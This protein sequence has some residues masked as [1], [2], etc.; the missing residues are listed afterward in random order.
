MANTVIGNVGDRATLNYAGQNTLIKCNII[1]MNT[2]ASVDVSDM[3]YQ[4]ELYEDIMSPFM[5]GKIVLVDTYNLPGL[6]PILGEE[7]FELEYKTPSLDSVSKLFYIYSLSDRKFQGLTKTAYELSFMSMEGYNDL[8]QRVSAAYSGTPSTIIQSVFDKY[9]KTEVDKKEEADT[10]AP[11]LVIEQST[12]DIKFISNFWNPSKII[13]Y[14]TSLAQYNSKKPEISNFLFFESTQGFWFSPLDQLYA[15]PAVFDFVFD[16]STG[17]Q[18]D[19]MGGTIED[20]DKQYRLIQNFEVLDTFDFLKR[21][22]SGALSHQVFEYNLLNKRW[23]GIGNR[24]A[25]K[26]NSTAPEGDPKGTPW[27]N[28]PRKS[29]DKLNETQGADDVGGYYYNSHYFSDFGNTEHLGEGV[30]QGQYISWNDV[31]SKISTKITH[32]SAHTGVIDASADILT[33][34]ASL[35]AQTE[36]VRFRITVMGRSDLDVGACVNIQ[37]PSFT[38]MHAK[39]MTGK[40]AFPTDE[41]DN[42]YDEYWTGKYLITNIRHTITGADH[43]AIIDVCRESLTK[44]FVYT[45]PGEAIS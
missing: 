24:I 45:E 6:F 4:I 5:S 34:R 32:S 19:G 3:I 37:F 2:D 43:M 8:S 41:K 12:N 20:V 22:M 1:S 21:S 38:Q 35:L 27:W 33:K 39:T 17:R 42:P 15:Q 28:G 16:A 40:D 9:L 13:T 7:M 31:N 30:L 18:S 23:S 10:G 14:A 25:D 29:K 11:T 26:E 44:D 36:M